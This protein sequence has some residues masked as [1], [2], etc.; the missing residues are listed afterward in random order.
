MR[1]PIVTVL[2]VS[3]VALALA[4]CGR[5][6]AKPDEPK[7]DAGGGIEGIEWRLVELDGRPA[8][9]GAD[10]QPA[11]LLL[12]AGDHRAAGFAG[13]N[14]LAGTY[15]LS[16]ERV[17]LGPLVTTRMACPDG[18]DLEQRY[19]AALATV[20]AYQRTG[21]RLELRGDRGIVARFQAP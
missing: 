13:C 12:T 4:G 21:D 19:T 15:E 11:T 10:G 6:G 14:R 20:T 5:T 3:L 8:G 18:M 16:P 17:R 7:A 9:V 2:A 1:H